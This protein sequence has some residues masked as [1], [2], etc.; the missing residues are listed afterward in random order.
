M[1][2]PEFTRVTPSAEGGRRSVPAAAQP[3]PAPVRRSYTTA[4]FVVC[5]GRVLLLN[6]RRY[7]KWLPPGGHLQ[8]HEL[9][10]E[11][12][13][14]E[15][16]EE[17]GLAVELVGE[18]GLPVTSPRQLVLPRG[19]QVRPAGPGL[20]H[21]DIVYFARPR[22]WTGPGCPPVQLGPEADRAVWAGPGEL[23]SL[24]VTEEIRLWAQKALRELDGPERGPARSSWPAAGE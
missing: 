10:D 17:T 3:A 18:R 13:V 5:D 1:S 15:V 4:V 11:A 21:V 2:A 24:G 9:P 12:A 22:A 16:Y 20:E 14:R 23:D 6:H 8:P 19:L 7:G